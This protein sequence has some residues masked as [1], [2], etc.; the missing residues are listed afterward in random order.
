[1]GRLTHRIKGSIKVAFL[2][3]HRRYLPLFLD[4]PIHKPANPLKKEF[5]KTVRR[6]FRYSDKTC[7]VDIMLAFWR[8]ALHAAQL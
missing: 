7:D 8:A 4:R 5:L 3:K 6:R 2:K 1:M